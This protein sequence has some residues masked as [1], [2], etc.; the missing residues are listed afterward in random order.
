MKQQ[1]YL[2]IL[3]ALFF[4]SKVSAQTENADS[5]QQKW[6]L[7]GISGINLSQTAMSNWAAGGENAIASNIYLNGSLT[8]AQGNW[9][10]ANYLALDYGLSKTKSQGMRKSTDK[11]N[12]STQLGYSIGKGWYYTFM[13]D[14]NTQF[15]KGYN[16]PDKSHY[17]ST[18]FA[19]AYSTLSI[20]MEYRKKNYSVFFSPLSAKMTFVAD[21]YLSSLG[22]FG[23]KPGKHFKM[24]CGAFLKGRT[25][26]QLME[27]VNVISTANLFTPYSDQ[28]GNIDIDWDVLL[29]LKINKFLSAT[30]NT[31]LK[32]D[33]DIKT[34]D[35]EGNRHGAKVQ[36]K[37]ILGIGFAYNF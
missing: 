36:F 14:L 8:Y 3:L 9:L 17:I 22:T 28:F 4:I 33:N 2:L 27:N 37:E 23:V 19:P 29:N 32:Y 7:K 15:A 31:T 30:I 6:N 24:E 12:F 5:I 25:E 21:D 35:E 11:I 34:F 13:G 1:Y 18:F 20:G 10:W 26:F 16:Y